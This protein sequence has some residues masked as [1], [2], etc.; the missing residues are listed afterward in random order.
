MSPPRRL[1][2]WNL[3][4][5]LLLSVFL[6][7]ELSAWAQ[8]DPANS[9][10]APRATTTRDEA[11]SREAERRRSVGIVLD[12]LRADPLVAPYPILV[13]W[14]DGKVSL[15]GKVG[16]KTVYD[17]AIRSVIDTGIPFR[18]SLVIDTAETYRVAQAA[19]MQGVGPGNFQGL[20]TSP[21]PYIY[22]PPLFGRVDDPFFGLEP[23]VVSF[24]AWW[25]W[26][27]A[28]P[29]E[30]VARPSEAPVATQTPPASQSAPTAN[31]ST[32]APVLGRARIWMDAYGRVFLRGVV[33]SEQ[34]KDAIEQEAASVP[35]VADVINELTVENSSA[36]PEPP[37]PPQPNP[38]ADAVKGGLKEPKALRPSAPPLSDQVAKALSRRPAKADQSVH[39]AISGDTVTL[40]GKVSSA[41]EAML[42][43]RAAQQTPGVNQ[44]V[45]Q[46][47][48]PLPDDDSTN[49]LIQKGRP[50]DVRPY[51]AEHIRKNLGDSAHL[52]R[53]ELRGDVLEIHGS[54]THVE[55]R[56]RIAAILR[57]IPILRG[58]QIESSFQVH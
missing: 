29:N 27:P 41:Y 42:A 19:T 52:D 44:V 31:P 10:I 5:A 51:L 6:T 56:K 2:P 30:T 38:P 14:Q 35:G 36:I 43:F 57:S 33:A 34:I 1:A 50:E 39:V 4:R 37:P 24:P 28:N 3:H 16:T 22:P 58:F 20:G 47:E 11:T 46:L 48:F 49:P 13:S 53:I 17:L 45:D 54:I 21:L 12:A 25:G 55:D 9:S 8:T 40:S 23:P 32:D 26:R 18:E 15:T 7:P